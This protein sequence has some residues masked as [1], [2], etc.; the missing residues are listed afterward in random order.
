M[1]LLLN[2]GL[3][4]QARGEEACKET[5]GCGL[6]CMLLLWFASLLCIFL[7]GMMRWLR[8]ALGEIE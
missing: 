4:R 6:G 2:V 1:E 8:V 7:C 5:L 3:K